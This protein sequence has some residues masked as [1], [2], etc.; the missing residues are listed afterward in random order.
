VLSLGALVIAILLASALSLSLLALVNGGL[1]YARPYQIDELDRQVEGLNTQTD[2]LQQDMDALRT[3]IDNI[4]GLSGR[5]GEAERA[6]EAVN[7]EMDTA[8]AQAD[9]LRQR[10]DKLDNALGEMQARTDRFQGF[11]EGLQQLLQG[12]FKP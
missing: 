12:L 5:V 3:R 10:V 1:N 6:I 2:L 8:Q 7:K 9:T 4:E 11:L